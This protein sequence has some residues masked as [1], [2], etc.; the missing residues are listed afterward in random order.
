M[1]IAL[2]SLMSNQA[3]AACRREHHGRLIAYRQARSM[4]V[5]EHAVLQFEDEQT[6]RYQLQEMLRVERIEDE[7]EIR[8]QIDTYTAL[9]PNGENW[10]ATLMFQIPDA[11]LRAALLS[12]LNEITRRFYIKVQGHV[13]I[14]ATANE[15]LDPADHRPLAVHFLR[16]DLPLPVRRA[17]LGGSAVLVGCDHPDYQTCTVMR[18]ELRDLLAADLSRHSRTRVAG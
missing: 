11:G 1:S 4:L 7:T 9:L 16:F 18:A 6:I 3:Y 13:P 17:A 12:R 2:P 14:H 10:K 5:G 8:E 15:D